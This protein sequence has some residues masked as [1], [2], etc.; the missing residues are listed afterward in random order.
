MRVVTL[1][2]LHIGKWGDY[3]D[4]LIESAEKNEGNVLWLN[5]DIFEP[6]GDEA[7]D[8][9]A[10]LK[11][12]GKLHDRYDH[13]VW[14]A[15]NNDLE[16]DLLTGPVSDYKRELGDILSS[17]RI[18]LLDGNPVEVGEFALIGNI[19]WSN[20]GLWEPSRND[21]EWPNSPT[22]NRQATEKY[23]QELFGDRWDVTSHCFFE[24]V[25]ADLIADVTRL[26]DKR[27]ILGT[28]YVTSPKFVLYGSRPKYDYL[29]WYMG[30]DGHGMYN[31]AKP[32]LAMVGHTHRAQTELVG[33]TDVHNISGAREPFVFEL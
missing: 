28:H 5:G 20:G 11:R 24:K 16:W 19:G 18:H 31:F 22:Q 30:W 8:I 17:E 13:V 26:G 23:F 10:Y 2:D 15:G 25:Q 32:E 29:N 6:D 1:S 7:P 33:G 12:L 14:V 21:T 3:G 9:M 4:K 27:I